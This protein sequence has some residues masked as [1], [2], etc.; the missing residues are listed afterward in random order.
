MKSSIVRAL[1]QL[2]LLM[3]DPVWTRVLAMKTPSD[4]RRQRIPIGLSLG[5]T[6]VQSGNVLFENPPIKVVAHEKAKVIMLRA[7][8]SDGPLFSLQ[9]K[10]LPLTSMRSCERVRFSDAE[11]ARVPYPNLCTRG[12]PHH[13]LQNPRLGSVSRMMARPPSHT[14]QCPWPHIRILT[15]MFNQHRLEVPLRSQVPRTIH[16]KS[17]SC[18]TFLQS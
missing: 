1:V 8:S 4:D 3:S 5:T 7:P 9:R 11:Q 12:C 18:C 10:A 2:L 17:S 6:K 14:Y 15:S 16:C 13:L